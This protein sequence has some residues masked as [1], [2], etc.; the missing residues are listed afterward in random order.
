MFGKFKKK[1][2]CNQPI[3]APEFKHSAPKPEKPKFKTHCNFRPNQKVFMLMIGK[4]W[5]VEIESLEIRVDH[6]NEKNV[7]Y[8]IHNNPAGT[9]FTKCFNESDLFETKEELFKSL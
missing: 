7:R 9:Q 3:D 1:T 4:V 6:H 8:W 2:L 5:P